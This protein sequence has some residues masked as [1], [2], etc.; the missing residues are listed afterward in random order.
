MT[1]S[2]LKRDRAVMMSSTIPSAKYSCSGSELRLVKGRTAIEGLLGR[3]RVSST[4]QR[5][6][7]TGTA[8]PYGTRQTRIGSA[9][10]FKDCEPKSSVVRDADTARLCNP[11]ET[12]RNIDP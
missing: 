4:G 1:N 2:A 11:F 10:F 8:R 9:I 5:F 7:T 6:G 12:H 3:A